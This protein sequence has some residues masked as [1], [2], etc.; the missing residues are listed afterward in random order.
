MK[1]YILTMSSAY[2]GRCIYNVY[3]SYASAQKAMK[4]FDPNEHRLFDVEV[5]EVQKEV[6]NDS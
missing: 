3:S 6:K 2:G 4:D 1:V 5:F